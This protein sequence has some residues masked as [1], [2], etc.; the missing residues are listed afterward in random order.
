MSIPA[1][2]CTAYA[3]AGQRAIN[4]RFVKTEHLWCSFVAELSSNINCCDNNTFHEIIKSETKKKQRNSVLKSRCCVVKRLRQLNL[5]S[6]VIALRDSWPVKSTKNSN[7]N[8]KP[9]GFSTTRANITS[10]TEI[11]ATQTKESEM[12]RRKSTKK[13]IWRPAWKKK[14][15]LEKAG[16]EEMRSP[17]TLSTCSPQRGITTTRAPP[18]RPLKYQRPLQQTSQKKMSKIKIKKKKKKRKSRCKRKLT[19]I[20][21]QRV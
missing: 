14:E 8:I 12:I 20:T 3:A 1:W 17:T 9:I 11:F 5:A 6:E 19:L 18:F 2:F 21:K 7:I 13:S 4:F 10:A 15:K 16:A